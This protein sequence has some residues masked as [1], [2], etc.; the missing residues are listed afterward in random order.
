MK[1]TD[2]IA[3]LKARANI[4]NLWMQRRIDECDEYNEVTLS[5]LVEFERPH[6]A[7]GG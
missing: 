5:K 3:L 6:S 1:Q 7:A 2:K 4:L